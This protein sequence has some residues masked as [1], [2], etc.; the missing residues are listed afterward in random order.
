[1]KMNQQPLKFQ[2]KLQKSVLLH[3]KK[4]EQQL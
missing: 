1:M 2:Q 4:S 3:W